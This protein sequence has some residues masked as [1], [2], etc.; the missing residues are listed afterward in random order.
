[1]R[2]RF[3]VMPEVA[4]GVAGRVRALL[5]LG[6]LLP[7]PDLGAQAISDKRGPIELSRSSSVE[8]SS[9]RSSGTGFLIADG[10]VATAFH[11][12]ASLAASEGAKGWSLH[13]ELTV[14]L[15][16]GERLRATCVTVPSPEDQTP[17]QYDFAV[18]RL[19][20][21][22]KGRHPRVELAD[23]AERFAVG[24]DIVFSGFPLATP[25]LVTHKGMISGFDD[26]GSIIVLQAAINKGNSG[27]AVLTSSG[28]AIGIISMREGGISKGLAELSAYIESVSGKNTVIIR[29]VDPLE[30]TR[31][32]I[33][34]LD[35]YI[36]T[37]I[38]YA[39]SVRPLRAYLAKHPELM[40]AP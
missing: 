29:G 19:E 20:A 32:I 25:G 28:K 7:G 6:L 38:G 5:L 10:Y 23:P 39:I 40:R 4:V 11:V 27:G 12:V 13:P 26:T 17:L 30:S 37:G 24:D 34:T 9:Q 14:K 22:P 3:A 2:L 35:R 36:S 31:A 16:D 15:P 1:M 18:L 8:V 33:Q 21:K